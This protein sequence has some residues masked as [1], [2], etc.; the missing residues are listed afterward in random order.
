MTD[1][2]NTTL[3]SRILRGVALSGA[4]LAGFVVIASIILWDSDPYAARDKYERFK[5]A[6]F[7]EWQAADTW[8]PPGRQT[9][10]CEAVN[11]FEA[12]LEEASDFTFFRNT[13][14]KGT[15]LLVQTGIRFATARDV[16]DRQ[17]SSQWCYVSVPNN[18]IS[19]QINLAE[20]SAGDPPVY[21]SLASLDASALAGS[22]LSV[23]ALTLIARSHC[24][25]ENTK[26]MEDN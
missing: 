7:G 10:T 14:I 4:G 6:M 5:I 9:Q 19:Q 1:C 25:F 20:Q 22:G 13:P 24:R 18:G 8:C 16:V 3:I 12:A 23:N 17:T 26:P 11:D 15:G 21:T 2:A